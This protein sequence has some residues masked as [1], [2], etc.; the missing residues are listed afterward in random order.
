MPK[1][2]VEQGRKQD[3]LLRITPGIDPH[4]QQK[5]ATG[6]VDSKFGFPESSREQAVKQAM[7]SPGLNLVGLHFHIGSLIFETQPYLEALTVLLN[8]AAEMKARHN[9]VLKELNVGG[10]FAIQYVTATPAPPVK[11]LC[12]SFCRLY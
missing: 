12:R 9:F 4:T 10:G 5:I 7:S 6:N 8:F 2:A 3:I 11:S 1:L